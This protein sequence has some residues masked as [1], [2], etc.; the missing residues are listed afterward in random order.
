MTMLFLY[1]GIHEVVRKMSSQLCV[2][3]HILSIYP[4]SHKQLRRHSPN[5]FHEF[6]CIYL[7]IID[8]SLG[9]CLIKNFALIVPSLFKFWLT[10]KLANP[11]TMAY[12]PPQCTLSNFN[13]VQTKPFFLLFLVF[14]FSRRIVDPYG[15]NTFSV[16]A[17][18]LRIN[19]L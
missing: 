8:D 7:T 12:L 14:F 1:G 10:V 6:S 17:P 9:I 2:T 3:L 15:G 5:P 11:L 18:V 19:T 16:K 4:S 13:K